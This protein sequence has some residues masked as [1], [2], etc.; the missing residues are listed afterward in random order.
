MIPRRNRVFLWVAPV[1]GVGLLI[2]ALLSPRPGGGALEYVAIGFLLGTMF[3]QG[4]LVSA[5]TA[6]GPAPLVW[7]LPLSLLWLVLLVGA[8]AVSVARSGGP[9]V[10]AIVV[11]GGCLVGQWLLVQVPLWCLRLGYGVRL[12]HVDDTGFLLDPRDRQFG[13]RQLMIFTTIIAVILG[14]GRFLVTRLAPHLTL[15]TS[16]DGPLFI[17]LA[18]AA[19]IVTLPLMLAALLPRLAV[20]AVIS[21]LVLVGLLTAWEIPLLSRFHGGGGRPDTMHMVAINSVTAA[22]VLAVVVIVRFNGYRL[23]LFR[24]VSP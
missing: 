1:I 8:L 19:I 6:F 14:A 9:N 10:E 18:V 7:R 13:I 15:G 5:W 22:W 4:T 11:I 23:S 24:G 16:G 21:I 12:R 2:M 20:P 17:F 3:G